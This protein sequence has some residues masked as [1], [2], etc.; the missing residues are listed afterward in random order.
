[1]N[2]AAKEFVHRQFHKWYAKQVCSQLQQNTK[3]SP[4]DL[5]LSIVKPLGAWWMVELHDY[6]KGKPDIIHNG[7][8]GQDC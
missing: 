4:I 7:F 5:C 1:M 8:K 3:E 6:L 2:K